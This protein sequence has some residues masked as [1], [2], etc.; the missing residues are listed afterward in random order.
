MASGSTPDEVQTL[1][2][3]RRQLFSHLWAGPAQ[4]RLRTLKAG[5]GKGKQ[6]ETA[7]NAGHPTEAHQLLPLC[8]G[9]DY[10]D[11]RPEGLLAGCGGAETS[12]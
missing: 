10:A 7:G 11:A 5:R 2:I 1:Q 8:R 3:S 9:P 6:P 4:E 12:A